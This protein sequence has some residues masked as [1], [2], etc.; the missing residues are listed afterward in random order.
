MRHW[1]RRSLRLDTTVIQALIEAAMQPGSGRL[2]L[3]DETPAGSASGSA[4]A[5]QHLA[6]PAGPLL[7]FVYHVPARR[8]YLAPLPQP[9]AAAQVGSSSRQNSLHPEPLLRWCPFDC[10][11]DMQTLSSSV[12]EGCGRHVCTAGLD[13]GGGP[14]A[15]CCVWRGG[16]RRRGRPRCGGRAVAQPDAL[17]GRIRRRQGTEALNSHTTSPSVCIEPHSFHPD[18]FIDPRDG[19]R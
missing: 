1:Q 3:S 11:F 15:C 18:R 9:P 4:P 16:D 6:I 8:Q 13:G 17:S 19:I 14:L 2:R 7:H 12:I 10:Q 5:E